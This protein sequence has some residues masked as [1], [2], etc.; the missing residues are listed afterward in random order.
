MSEK[1]CVGC[2]FLYSHDR[3]Y[4]NYTVEETEM[5]CAKDRNSKLPADVP[6]DWKQEPDN[7]PHTNESR[8]DLYAAG[9]FIRLDVDG[10][11]TAAQQTDDAEVIALIDGPLR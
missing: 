4:S 5:I 2:K 8:C 7:W 11:Y 10:E 3:G 6:Y 1:S 9:P